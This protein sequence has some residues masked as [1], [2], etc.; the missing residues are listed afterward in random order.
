M[1]D[2]LPFW[3]SCSLED[4]TEAQWE[5]LCD[6]CGRCC[7]HKL[8]DDETGEVF[9]TDI[10]CELLD[11]ET[12]CC[13]DYANRKQTVPDCLRLTPELAR[14]IDWLP[15]TCAYRRLA[16]GKRLPQWHPLVTGNPL[17]ALESGMSALNRVITM[18]QAAEIYGEELDK[19]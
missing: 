11:L 15:P 16:E 4:L 7:V 13:R 19:S 10:A 5:S 14:S 6:R 12:C 2:G 18:D 17:S 1:S 8:Q 3:D 9:V